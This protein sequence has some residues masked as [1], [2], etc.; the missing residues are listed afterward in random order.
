MNA[1][2]PWEIINI[3]AVIHIRHTESRRTERYEFVVYVLVFG[4]CR[5]LPR[6]GNPYDDLE[7]EFGLKPR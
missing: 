2:K 3:K 1:V 4:G 5:K 6:F 7:K